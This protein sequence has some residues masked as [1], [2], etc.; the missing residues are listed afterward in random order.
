MKPSSHARFELLHAD[1]LSRY[2][3][4]DPREVRFLLKQIATKRALISAYPDASTA[5]GLTT[6]LAV[7][8]EEAVILDNVAEPELGARLAA[9]GRVLCITQLDNVKVQF[10]LG[11]LEAVRFDDA[12]AWR[13]AVPAHVLRLQRREYYRLTA[14]VSHPLRCV[15]PLPQPDGST[16]WHEARILDISAGG[17]AIV[18]PPSGMEFGA[19]MSFPGCRIELP[20]SAPMTVTLKVRNLFRVTQRNGTDVVRAGCQF[21]GLTAAM[22]T[23]IQRYILRVERER[24][25]RAG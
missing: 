18:A 12:P 20:D 9:A 15:M 24:A 14:P 8:D 10:E 3:V 5:F 19:E 13:A 25:N 2:Q 23:A 11:R 16:L 21:V 1:D 4:A 22:D 7:P 17:V 6:I